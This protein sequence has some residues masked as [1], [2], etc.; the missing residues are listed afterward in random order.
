[1]S[2]LVFRSSLLAAG[3]CLL[4]AAAFVSPAHAEDGM[5][6][7]SAD[8]KFQGIGERDDT[9]PDISE[10][11]TQSGA[12]DLR[13]KVTAKPYTDTTIYAEGRAVD[14]GGNLGVDDDTGSTS[15]AEDFVEWRQSWIKFTDIA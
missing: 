1:M 2:S 7:I 3:F 12:A 4:S 8:L 11:W 6:D 14:I 5:I 13:V 10:D 15:S 9:L